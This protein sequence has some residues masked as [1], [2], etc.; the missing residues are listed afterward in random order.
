MTIVLIGERPG[1]SSPDSL[2]IYLTWDPK[3]G[4]S[5]AERN[6]ISNIRAEGLS[7]SAAAETLIHLMTQ[8]RL[9]GLS[10]V[11]LEPEADT[12]FATIP[13]KSNPLH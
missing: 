1:L 10:G 9:R 7:Y 11:R 8:V 6:C 2:G 4:R 13:Q 3:P 5:D 12:P